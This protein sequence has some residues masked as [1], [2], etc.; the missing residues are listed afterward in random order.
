MESEYRVNRIPFF[1]PEPRVAYLL[2]D[3]FKVLPH[4]LARDQ[5]PTL[6]GLLYY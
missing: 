3:R 6:S 2:R 5:P 4:L 1:T